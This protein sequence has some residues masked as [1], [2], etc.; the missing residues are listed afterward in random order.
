MYVAMDVCSYECMQLCMY[1][2]MDVCSYGL[3][4]YGCI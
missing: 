4:S 2:A 3:C 1:V